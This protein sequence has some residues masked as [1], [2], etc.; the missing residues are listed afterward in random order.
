MGMFI[1]VGAGPWAASADC[2]VEDGNGMTGVGKMGAGMVGAGEAALRAGLSE[3]VK[4]GAGIELT[5]SDGDMA[6][7]KPGIAGG[8]RT[9]SVGAL[10]V[11]PSV[12]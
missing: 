3:G 2:D 8:G 1:G 10:V 7:S 6:G 11:I 4:D 9:G 5:N 12:A